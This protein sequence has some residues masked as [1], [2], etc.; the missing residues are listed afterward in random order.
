MK[1]ARIAALLALL[2]MLL[3]AAVGAQ[4]DEERA[5][6]IRLLGQTAFVGGGADAFQLR[7]RVSAES[8][9]ELFVRAATHGRLRNRAAFAATLDD[10]PRNAQIDAAEMPLRD[11]PVDDTG[12]L[13]FPVP[14]IDATAPG[15]YPVRVELRGVG[16]V[17]IDGFTTHLVRLPATPDPKPLRVA[18]V[19]PVHAPPAVLPDGS[20][21]LADESAASLADVAVSLA[22]HS[23][24]LNIAATP[25]TIEALDKNVVETIAASLPGRVLLGRTFVATDP[26]GLLEDDLQPALANAVARGNAS[27]ASNLDSTPAIDTWLADTPI[28]TDAAAEF[29]AL[30][31]TRF[32]VPDQALSELR[33]RTTLTAPF[34]LDLRTGERPLALSIDRQISAHFDTADE[35]PVLAAHHLLAEL[36]LT[37][38]EAPATE[39]GIVVAPDSPWPSN[40]D[41]VEALLGGLDTTTGLFRSVSLDEV[42]DDVPP[43]RARRSAVVRRLAEPET[44]MS[45]DTNAVQETRT[46]VAA[47]ASLI[48]PDNLLPLELE[49]AVLASLALGNSARVQRAYLGGVNNR[50]RGQLALVQAPERRSITLTARRGEIPVTIRNG[51]PYPVRVRVR[52]D[53]DTLD[54]PDGDVRDLELQ[55]GAHTERFT[56]EA[57]SSGA[58]R[59]RVLIESPD[60]ALEI[61]NTRFTVRS[62]ATSGVGLAL[63]IGA[64]GFLM[65]WWASHLR[66]R[67]SRRLV[68]A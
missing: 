5:G 22:R 65:V 62:T 63:S 38:T 66:G 47:F 13:L 31:V 6:D 49:G 40:A 8:G 7:L 1:A 21:R 30:G 54:F 61:A 35:E 68:P 58:F 34:E 64:G 27:L 50:I 25:E 19:I 3:P 45:F 42:F 14:I 53:S 41:F 24:P 43:L 9:E 57:R 11:V 12:A 46:R 17:P 39:R 55:P 2:L 20:S 37:A 67:R 26:P 4:E 29:R 33:L 32:V 48:G 44:S 16:G 23:S 60:G 15:V 10:R 56:V 28:S 51:T 18:V 59:L 52:L 36:A